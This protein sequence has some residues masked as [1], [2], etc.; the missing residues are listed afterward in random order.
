MS[1]ACSYGHICSGCDL[2]PLSRSQVEARRRSILKSLGLPSDSITTVWIEDGGLRNHL[3]FTYEPPNQGALARLGLYQKSG[4][5]RWRQV[6][7]LAGCAQLTPE[8]ETWLQTF[9]RDLPPLKKKAGIRLRVAPDGRRGVWIDT[10]NEEVRDLLLEEQWLL[11][12]L[13]NGIVVEIG[14]RRKLVVDSA[15]STERRL[16]LVDPVLEA[17][18]QTADGHKIYGTIASFTQPGWKAAAKLTNTVLKHVA[19]KP[20]IILEFG[21]GSGGFTLPLLSRRHRVY[22]FEFD[23]LAVASLKKGVEQFSDE[24]RSCLEVYEGDFIQS[25][26]AWKTAKEN[27]QLST[28]DFA[29]A[30]ALVDPPR[31]GLGRFLETLLNDESSLPRRWVYVSCNPESFARDFARLKTAGFELEEL[32]VVEQFPYTNHFELVAS[33]VAKPK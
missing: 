18:F 29:D 6:V 19:S 2:L 1:L 21:A 20:G 12:Q 17:W 8:L 27:L 4:L 28:Q 24:I 23:Q 7:D 3:E 26:R 5:M 10:A 15:P 13:A 16:R 31:S 30:T 33:I 14:Q 32:T 9:R 11:R 22:A 25:D